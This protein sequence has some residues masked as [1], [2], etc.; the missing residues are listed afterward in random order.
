MGW[1]VGGWV[2]GGLG[3]VPKGAVPGDTYNRHM[4]GSHYLPPRGY[5][6]VHL[7]EE[8]LRLRRA[9]FSGS[10]SAPCQAASSQFST[11]S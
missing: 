8:E 10:S 9:W 4:Q 11:H 7:T 1:L 5:F 6:N 3:A 2:G